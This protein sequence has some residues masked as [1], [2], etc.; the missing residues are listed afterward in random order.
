MCIRDRVN[1][2]NTLR[3]HVETVSQS[4]SLRFTIAGIISLL[5]FG[6]LSAMLNTVGAIRVT[7]FSYTGYGLD[8][9]ALYGIFSFCAFGAIYFIVPRITRREW[10]SRRFINWHFFLS[11]YGIA[12]I[13]CCAVIGG[14]FQ[15]EGVEAHNQSFLEAA[16]RASSYGWGI[17][18]AW[19]FILISNI[20][21]CL[22]PVSYTHLTLPTIY[23][24]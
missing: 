15:G 1:I 24:V 18:I 19:F 22:H 20:F 8:I 16:A 5:L 21:F 14:Y 10:L 12:S 3:G 11:L 7:Q 13:V 6:L 4:P 23:S 9:L 17:T 2:L